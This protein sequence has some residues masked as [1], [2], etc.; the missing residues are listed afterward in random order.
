MVR[1]QDF[2]VIMPAEP[3]SLGRR[4]GQFAGL[5]FTI[6]I[7]ILC[8]RQLPTAWLNLKHLTDPERFPKQLVEVE[9]SRRRT[10]SI[11]FDY[12]LKLRDERDVP[13][14]ASGGLIAKY[15]YNRLAEEAERK[16]GKPQ[17][18]VIYD[19]R[20]PA[21]GRLRDRMGGVPT[22]VILVFGVLYGAWEV[23]RLVKSFRRE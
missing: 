14:T 13:G 3:V 16:G 18:E 21:R 7:V 12:T 9:V 5:G 6:L 1:E 20:S 4:I 8:L 10:L 15:Q 23:E 22:L 11:T 19:V 17:F 2:D